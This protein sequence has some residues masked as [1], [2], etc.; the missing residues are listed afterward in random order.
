M[1]SIVV[2]LLSMFYSAQDVYHSFY[3]YDLDGLRLQTLRLQDTSRTWRGW[4][5]CTQSE[6]F[7]QSE[8]CIS[9]NKTFNI[10]FEDVD[11]D[12]SG[13]QPHRGA[14]AEAGGVRV[15]SQRSLQQGEII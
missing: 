1:R 11:A 2:K 10:S 5:T 3:F 13:R 4:R 6:Y 12:G 9:S 8:P 15:S 7:I 14:E